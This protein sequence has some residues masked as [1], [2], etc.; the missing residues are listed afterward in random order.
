MKKTLIAM[1]VAAISF[2][3]SAININDSNAVAP[4]YAAELTLPVTLTEA[5]DDFLTETKLGFSATKGVKRYVRFDLSGSSFD[6]AITAADLVLTR[7][8][9]TQVSDDPAV[10]FVKFFDNTEVEV[11]VGQG[12]GLG[13]TYVIFEITPLADDATYSAGDDI[14]GGVTVPVGADDVVVTSGLFIDDQVSFN[15]DAV[16]AAEKNGGIEYRLY[17][18]AVEAAAASS[19]ILWGADGAL[20]EMLPAL[21]IGAK[22]WT[23]E[24]IDVAQ[25]SKYFEGF[26][27][28]MVALG[29]VTVGIATHV[30]GQNSPRTIFNKDSG[31]VTVANIFD[32]ISLEVEGDFSAGEK[33]GDKLSKDAL[34]FGGVADEKITLTETKATYVLDPA[35]VNLTNESVLFTVD[36]E[37]EIAEQDVTAKLVVEANSGYEASGVNFGII[38]TLVKNGSE[39]ELDLA[40][41][42]TASFS[43]YVRVTN[44]T[45][46]EGDFW[47]T[48]IAD[49]GAAVSFSLDQVAGQ[50]ATIAPQAS[51]EQMPINAI[52]A[53]AAANGLELSGQG[54][55]RIVVNGQVPES[56]G[57]ITMQAY[58]VAKDGSTFSTWNI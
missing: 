27:D 50:S 43:N 17:E 42:P 1:A 39:A 51:T 40:L 45:N 7:A 25:E 12:G 24:K 53:A 13:D 52:F 57:G 37:T 41:N 6:T 9:F 5:N 28:D 48:V 47:M 35:T 34:A 38:G 15:I 33:D 26:E 23:Q 31:A 14:P 8:M 36:G 46:V 19:E 32:K 21:N 29:E 11:K 49:D 2:N 30:D 44:K 55:L 18:T 20:Y 56:Q 4:L 16:K 54:K 3:A 22:Y 10:P 58:T